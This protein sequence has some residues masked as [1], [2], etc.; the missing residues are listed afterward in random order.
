VR[1]FMLSRTPDTELEFDFAKAVE[2][3]K[4]NPVFYVQYAHARCCSVLRNARAMW[5][6]MDVSAAALAQADVARLHSAEELHLVRLM[7][8][9]PRHVEA[10]AE[11]RESHR[12]AAYLHDLASEFHGFW[13]KGRDDAALRFLIERDRELSQARLA[14]VKAAATVIASGL[15]VMG[16]T[17]VEEMHG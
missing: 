9:W 11:A 6:D 10:A 3:S 2:Q 4:D 17:P 12:I 15:A 14:L 8:G 5:P 13:N 7:A 16:V 1:F